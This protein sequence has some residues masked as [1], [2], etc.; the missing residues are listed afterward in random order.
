MTILVETLSKLER[1]ITLKFALKDVYK[2][3]EKRLKQQASLAQ[4]PGFRLGKAPMKMIAAKFSNQIKMEVLN[5]IVNRSFY[6]IINENNLHVI[7]NPKIEQKSTQDDLQKDYVEFYVI[8]EVYPDIMI[9]ALSTVK[10]EK[11]VFRSKISDLDIDKAI[12]ILQKQ[13]TCYQTVVKKNNTC[14]LERFA[15]IGNR[16]TVDFSGTIN[17]ALFDSGQANNFVYILGEKYVLPEFETAVLGLKV[18]E[19]KNFSLVFPDQYHNKDIAGKKAKFTIKLK[20]IELAVQPQIDSE[21]VRSFGIQDGDLAKLREDI[22]CNLEREVHVRVKAKTKN[23]VMNALM[24][25]STL[26]VPKLLVEQDAERLL[27]IAH[28]DMLKR[29]IGVDNVQFSRDMFMVQAE[30]R[31]RLGLILSKI[32]KINNLEVTVEQVKAYIEAFSKKYNNP[33]QI[34]KYYMNNR[35]HFAEVQALVLEENVVNYVLSQSQVL[36]KS[37]TFNTLMNYES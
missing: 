26:D 28:E 27:K 8:F 23:N 6:K 16:V 32:V 19:S 20:K 14:D 34:A 7:G 24:Q 5:D 29:G 1:R 25:V 10:I 22:K 30:R 21:F 33:Q 37:V 12:K 13:R 15:Q 4:L 9:G 35:E 31:V 3:V 11:S 18:N 36:E 2:K 17:D